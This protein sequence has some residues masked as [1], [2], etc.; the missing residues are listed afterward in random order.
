MLV[1]D[2][3][4]W[5]RVRSPAPRA[6][7]ART[8]AHGPGTCQRRCPRNSGNPAP[9]HGVPRSHKHIT[10]GSGKRYRSES[11]SCDAAGSWIPVWWLPISSACRPRFN[12]RRSNPISLLLTPRFRRPP[13]RDG[14]AGR[15]PASQPLATPDPFAARGQAPPTRSL[16]HTHPARYPY[17]TGVL[18]VRVGTPGHAQIPDCPVP[19]ANVR[20]LPSP[21]VPPVTDALPQ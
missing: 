1:H 18:L 2:F 8:S 14:S 20:S 3:D 6:S 12:P 21:A 19:R 15:A 17:S 10:I 11:G 7:C 4:S 13:K 5:L 9:S 16:T